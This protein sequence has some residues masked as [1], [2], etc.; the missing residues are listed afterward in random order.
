[1]QTQRFQITP[2]LFVVIA[3]I[4]MAL[5]LP[6][7]LVIW[8]F[9][10]S[11]QPTTEQE[12]PAELRDALTAIA[13]KGLPPATVDSSG[14]EVFFEV[15][16]VPKASN[17]LSALAVE[18]GGTS[19]EGVPEEGALRILVSI[20]PEKFPEFVRQTELITG[21]KFLTKEGEDFSGMIGISLTPAGKP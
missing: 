13:D 6:I 14:R 10:G 19:L 3:L 9:V 4:L 16:D 8:A 5:A 21:T 20:P 18:L 11:N 15:V 17:S 12:A 7:G 1:M 2:Q